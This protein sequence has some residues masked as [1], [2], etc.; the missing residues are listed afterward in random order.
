MAATA[1]YRALSTAKAAFDQGERDAERLRWLMA[2]VLQS[3]PLARPQYVSYAD[4]DTLEEVEGPLTR[5]LLS[6]AVFIAKTRL[7]D[8]MLIGG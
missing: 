3:E 7:I 4:P 8:N 1:L 5:A 2:Q 6:L